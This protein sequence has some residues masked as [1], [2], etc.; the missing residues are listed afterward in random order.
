MHNKRILKKKMKRI[1]ALYFMH[2]QWNLKPLILEMA[3]LSE[4]T[5]VNM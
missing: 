1:E 4:K 3:Y 2:G 5:V